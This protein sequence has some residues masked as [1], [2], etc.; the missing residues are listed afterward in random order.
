MFRE[1]ESTGESV[2]VTDHGNPT[3][4]VRPYREME[5]SPL[6]MLKGSVI[7]YENPTDPISDD[8]WESLRDSP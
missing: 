4:E 7:E 8:E 2:I 6:D 5:R 3:I 1:V